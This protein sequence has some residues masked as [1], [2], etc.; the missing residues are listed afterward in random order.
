MPMLDKRT[1]TIPCEK[2][3]SGL[4]ALWEEGGATNSGGEATLIGG[5][6][7]GKA[8]ATFISL[9]GELSN[10]KHA[11]IPIHEGFVIAKGKRA[12]DNY[13]ITLYVVTE[14]HPDDN[15]PSIT[16][17]QINAFHDGEWEQP[18]FKKYE[19]IVAALK[20]KLTTYHCRKA[21][22]AE[23]AREKEKKWPVSKNKKKA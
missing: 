18:L 20:E 17:K 4:L 6:K 5:K 10:G 16:V 15:I 22:W 21:V 8:A 9:K 13:T 14:K 23:L 12:R 2:T 19:A 3:K 1:S 11:M 7:G